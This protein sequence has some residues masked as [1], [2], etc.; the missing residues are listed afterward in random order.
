M[1]KPKQMQF[2]YGG[3][4]YTYELYLGGVKRLNLRIRPDGSIRVSA[5][6]LTL[7]RRINDFLSLYGDKIEIISPEHIRCEFKKI[8]Q[9]M[10]AMYKDR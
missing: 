7:Q 4:V 6:L 10:M 5:P 3:K 8:L 9:R 1:N 2:T